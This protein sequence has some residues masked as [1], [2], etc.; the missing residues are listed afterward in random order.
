MLVLTRKK[1]ETVV[2]RMMDGT[3]VNIKITDIRGNRVRVGV[4]APKSVSV[5]RGEVDL[6]RNGAP[7]INTNKKDCE[8]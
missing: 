2:L 8:V 4:D 7:P 6:E 3:C 1:D 5:D